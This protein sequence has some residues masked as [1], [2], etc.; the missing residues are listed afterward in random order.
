MK[1]INVSSLQACVAS[2]ISDSFSC[3]VRSRPAKKGL[4][5][6]SL[7]IQ[8]SVVAGKCTIYLSPSLSVSD[9]SVKVLHLLLNV[10]HS[11]E[12]WF[13]LLSCIPFLFPHEIKLLVASVDQAAMGNN[14]PFKKKLHLIL[15][16][17][18]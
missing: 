5:G 6:G 14:M 13:D 8:T 10:E 1:K 3:S 4:L 12:V 11:V 15:M 7:Y 9:L 17:S 18:L 2:V 16:I